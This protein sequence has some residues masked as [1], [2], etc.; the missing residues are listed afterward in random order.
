M[1]FRS[2][3]SAIV[4]FACFLFFATVS[5]ATTIHYTDSG[6]GM[7]TP[8]SAE[9]WGTNITD[10][11]T[12]FEVIFDYTTTVAT[13]TDPIVLWEAGGSGNGAALVL[14][15]LNLHF[16]AGNGSDDVASGLHGLIPTAEDVQVVTTY[17]L[18]QNVGNDELLTIYVNGSQIG[19]AF[20]PTANDWAG[21]DASGLGSEFGTER[22][23]GTALFDDSMIQSFTDGDDDDI[24]FNLYD[25]TV[26][27]N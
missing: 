11:S 23:T 5:Q 19:T 4:G 18:D 14:D 8:S 13:E 24:T 6:V 16:F 3:I 20:V 26:A 17:E 27:G 9:S 1:N 10:K 21:T 25:L 12:A 15:G 7:F 2:H 22:Y